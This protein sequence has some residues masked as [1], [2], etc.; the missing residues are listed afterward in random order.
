[1]EIVDIMDMEILERM[2]ATQRRL[3]TVERVEL[4]YK[5]YI[6]ILLYILYVID[7]LERMDILH[8]AVREWKSNYTFVIGEFIHDITV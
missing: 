5:L 2:G 3:C 1:L 6:I 8:F 7:V 4:L